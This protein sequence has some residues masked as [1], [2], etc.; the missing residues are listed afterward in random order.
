MSEEKKETQEKGALGL[1]KGSVRALLT[2]GC[3]AV[4]AASG[5][6]GRLE[7]MAVFGTYSMKMLQDY[8]DKG[9][10]DDQSVIA[11]AKDAII[12]RIAK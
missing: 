3:L 8:A 1:N 10:A 11:R 12:D 6:L 2:F 5:F 4:T 9:K 7:L